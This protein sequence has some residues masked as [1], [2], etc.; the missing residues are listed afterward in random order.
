MKRSKKSSLSDL[1]EIESEIELLEEKTITY[2]G[3]E[4]TYR[5]EKYTVLKN[6]CSIVVTG[7]PYRYTA[8]TT[9]RKGGVQNKLKVLIKM[10]K[11]K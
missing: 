8:T 4:Y 1:P 2:E 3:H 9:C 6:Y 11:Q 7:G 5:V 10:L